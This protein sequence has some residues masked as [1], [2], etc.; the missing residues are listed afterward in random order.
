MAVI[1]VPKNVRE[2]GVLISKQTTDQLDEL[3]RVSKAS[4]NEFIE[5]NDVNDADRRVRIKRSLVQAYE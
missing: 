3:I 2:S 5:V 1:R 4:G